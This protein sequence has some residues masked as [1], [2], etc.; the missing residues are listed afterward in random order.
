M[1]ILPQQTAGETQIGEITIWVQTLNESQRSEAFEEADQYAA[2]RIARY[3]KT[4]TDLYA[5]IRAD[6]EEQGPEMQAGYLADQGYIDGT[7]HQAA[8][9]LYPTPEPIF[10]M[11]NEADERFDNRVEEG[12]ALREERA[13]LR[14]KHIEDS[15]NARKKAEMKSPAADR[16]ARCM[17]ALYA[18]KR[19]EAFTRRYMIEVIYRAVRRA[20][21]HAR[22]YYPSVEAVADLD[23]ATRAGLVEFYYS[24]DTV[25]PQQ[26]PTLAGAS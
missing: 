24:L 8:E 3:R 19:Q 26:V 25:T 4:D 13:R 6:F 15:Y 23:D 18:R 10:R 9:A 2:L 22:R 21:D 12:I 7:Y 1:A 11:E 14:D 16:V 5:S 17:R 20:E